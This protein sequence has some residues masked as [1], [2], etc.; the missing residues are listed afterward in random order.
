[1]KNPI[2]AESPRPSTDSRRPS[3]GFPRK[4]SDIS[5]KE[6]KRRFSLLPASFS[7]KGM[8]GSIKEGS[9]QR[10]PQDSSR[11]SMSQQS[12][13]TSGP[14]PRVSQDSQAYDG[15]MDPNRHASA[16]FPRMMANPPRS[17]PQPSHTRYASAQF[18][19]SRGSEAA[20]QSY[21][22]AEPNPTV[23]DLSFQ[24]Q[25][26]Q[27]SRP[28]Y[29]QGFNDY[30]DEPP[31]ASL[32]ASRGTRVLQKPNRKFQDAWEQEDPGHHAGSSGAAKR[33]MDFFRRRGKAR[34][35][36]DR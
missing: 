29:P 22:Y 26:Q 23:S 17:A 33:V 28:L 36:D 30:D 6:G 34:S 19:A 3:F 7:L 9:S 20:G 16:P 32:Q 1:M 8:T 24:Q 15:G 4:T 25:P 5:R 12:N 35:G 10:Y 18:P 14:V 13:F 31:R 27:Q 11:P 21:N 2:S